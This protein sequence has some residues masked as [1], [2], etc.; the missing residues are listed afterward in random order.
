MYDRSLLYA[1]DD[2]PYFISKQQYLADNTFAL[3]SSEASINK[4]SDVRQST[5]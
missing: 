4:V 5:R 3:S 1:I 2:I